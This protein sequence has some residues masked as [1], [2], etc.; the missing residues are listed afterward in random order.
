MRPVQEDS[1]FIQNYEDY[2]RNATNF[3]AAV[4]PQLWPA[5][6]AAEGGVFQQYKLLS[7]HHSSM[8][9]AELKLYFQHPL[10]DDEDK[11][12]YDHMVARALAWLAARCRWKIKNEEAVMYKG[13]HPVYVTDRPLPEEERTP[14]PQDEGITIDMKALSNHMGELMTPSFRVRN[15]EQHQWKKPENRKELQDLVCAMLAKDNGYKIIVAKNMRM[16]KTFYRI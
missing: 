15:E 5:E 9:P 7:S 6:M 16:D 11:A 13:A 10:Y 8:S 4:Y 2:D 3:G 12:A 1:M 14:L